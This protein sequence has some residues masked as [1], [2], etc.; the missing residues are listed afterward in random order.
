MKIKIYVNVKIID[1]IFYYNII[2]L[3][4]LREEGIYLENKGVKIFVN[5][6]TIFRC[7]FTFA[8]PFLIDNISNIAFILIIAIL[9]FTDCL[10]GFISRKY[11]AQTLFG[12]MMD[13]IADKVLCIVLI[14]CISNK[15]TILYMI[16]VGEILIATMNLIGTINSVPLVAIMVGKAKMWFLAVTTILGYV[17]YFGWC[18][19]I[20]VIVPGI[21]VVIMQ[22]FVIL[23]YGNKIRRVKEVR[24]EKIKFKKGAELKYALFNTE[25]Y[26]KTMDVSILEKLTMN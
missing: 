23:G 1:N 21:I 20:Y 8:M 13:T 15:T 26:L 11:N 24:K 22:I 18:D 17:Y 12:S 7:I 14:L 10:D 19:K 2:E 5:A 3:M 25:Y 4:V 6:L 16:L 9:F